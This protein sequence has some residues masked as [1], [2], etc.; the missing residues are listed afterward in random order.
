MK[1]YNKICPECK[2]SFK[3]KRKDKI[4]CSTNC[5]VNA[6]RRD[7][8]I[9][10]K[11]KGC[12]QYFIYTRRSPHKHYCSDK[13]KNLKTKANRDKVT[14]KYYHKNKVRINKR[15]GQ[16]Y[17]GTETITKKLKDKD[18]DLL[19]HEQQEQYWKQEEYAVK[20]IIRDTFKKP[21]R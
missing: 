14:K 9:V 4:Y 10:K 5:R 7:Q 11:C 1:E 16:T 20:A 13:C 3:A 19:T 8:E 2:K 21:K 17:K 12:K 18:F 6:H 15:I